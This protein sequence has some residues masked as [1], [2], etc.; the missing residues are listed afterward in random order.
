MQFSG[1]TAVVA[2]TGVANRQKVTLEL[3]N[4]ANGSGPAMAAVSLPIRFL[5]GDANRDGIV[6]AVDITVTRDAFGT[7]YGQTGF[8]A[9]GDIKTDSIINAVDITYQRDN[10]GYVVNP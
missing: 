1:S 3:S 10:F 2:L 9:E 5:I 4:F 8:K 6:N 7:T